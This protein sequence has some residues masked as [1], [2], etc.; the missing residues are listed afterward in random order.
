[1]DNLFLDSKTAI[2][3]GSS[4]GIGFAITNALLELGV[5][6]AGWS[7]NAPTDFSH[8]N[9]Y[10][11]S[12][13]IGNEQSVLESFEKAMPKLNNNIDYLINNAGI[14]HHAFIEETPPETWRQL[15]DVNVH[16]LFYASRLVIPVM[17]IRK[18]GHI[19]N[20][21]SG[22]GTNGIPG[23]SA[24]C[25]TKYA[26]NGITDTMHKELRNFGVKVTCLSPGSVETG[27]SSSDKNKILPNELAQSVIHIL[28]SPENF[29]YTDIQVRPL[30]PG[31]K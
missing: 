8:P 4:R 10:H 11:F 21:S 25:G 17:K 3:T 2:V 23:M 30:Q 16:G 31:K 19:I 7:R 14:G 27:F 12:T 24:Y 22:A 28:R 6:V 1:M 15:F 5:T 18:S 20:I 9:Y 26:V 29:H 13:D